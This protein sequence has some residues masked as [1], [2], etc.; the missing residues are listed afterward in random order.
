MN[1]I[2]KIVFANIII[3]CL[4]TSIS[5][6]SNDSHNIVSFENKMSVTENLKLFLSSQTSRTILRLQ[7][8]GI[9][10]GSKYIPKYEA[11]QGG[12]GVGAGVVFPL[13]FQKFSGQINTD[14][15]LTLGGSV[16]FEWDVFLWEG[17]S[18][19]MEIA[20]MFML[21]PND[22]TLFMAP[23]TTHI[24]Y[25]FQT[26]PIEFPISFAFGANMT[27]IENIFKADFIIK[28][29]LGVSYRINQNWTVG[30][31]TAYWFIVQS[32]SYTLGEEY[33][34][35]GNFIDTTAGFT[36]VF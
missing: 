35:L 25:T 13:F 23:I 21:T 34:R 33:S 17:L 28:P 36:Y 26:F 18:A 5:V 20:G 30:L 24:K 15:N 12:V 27:S 10:S 4:C 19:G 8:S 32:Y 22:R 7:D 9:K 6:Y 29:K 2:R 31:F 14:T 11:G 3:V 16:W 1:I